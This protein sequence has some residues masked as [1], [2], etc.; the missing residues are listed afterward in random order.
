MLRKFR[1]TSLALVF[2]VVASCHSA[3]AAA[4]PFGSF[5]AKLRQDALQQ[6]I[7]QQTV[8]AALPDFDPIGKVIELDGKQPEKKWTFADY[9]KRIVDPVRIRRGRELME[10]HAALLGDISRKY[11]VAPQY[12]VALWGIETNYGKNQGDFNTVRSLATLAWEGRRADFFRGELMLALKII[13][14]GHIRAADMKGSWAGA[15]GQNQFMPSSFVNFAQDGNGDGRK[16]IW[17]DLADVF[18]STANYLSRSG[19]KDGERWGREIRL[20]A[21]FN[22]AASGLENRRPIDEWKRMGITLPGGAAL[23]SATGMTAS[24]VL[25]DGVAGPAYLVYDNY[26]VFMKWNRSTYF[27]TSVGLIADAIA[28]A[29]R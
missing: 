17:N 29:P 25:P 14:Q 23:P 21:G 10:T 18:A 27:A 24:V 22:P 13:D 15:L 2:A 9:K 4:E 16:D 12:I 1:K 20:P 8:G 11:G 5:L 3:F 19:W 6:G 28:A 7:S 26:R